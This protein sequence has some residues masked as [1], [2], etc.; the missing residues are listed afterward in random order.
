MAILDFPK[1]SASFLRRRLI[2]SMAMTD[3]QK[4]ADRGRGSASADP[5]K[6]IEQKI[7][8]IIRFY[9]R[10]PKIEISKRICGLER[11]WSMERWLE[12]NTS[13][14]PFSGIIMGLTVNRKWFALPFLVTGFLFLHA[15]HGWCPPVT[16]LRK[17]G[18]RT[19]AEIER[20]KYALKVLRGDYEDVAAAIAEHV[21]RTEKVIA[22]VNA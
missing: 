10:L 1:V 22:A 19:R 17:M 18:V 7:E 2:M 4:E 13:G 6:R 3:R 11:E 14:L 15:M 9:S 5:L 21:G 20:E 12:T 8:A 16:L